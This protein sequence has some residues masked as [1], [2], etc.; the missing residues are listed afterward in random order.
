MHCV[1]LGKP[2]WETKLQS[3]AGLVNTKSGQRE[4]L[5]KDVDLT[6]EEY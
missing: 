5:I 6:K 3:E 4:D 2:A 1:P